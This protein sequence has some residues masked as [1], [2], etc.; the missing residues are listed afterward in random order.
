LVKTM[1]KLTKYI[2]FNTSNYDNLHFHNNKK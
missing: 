1:K 2:V